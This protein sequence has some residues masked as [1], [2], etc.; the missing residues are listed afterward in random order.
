MNKKVPSAIS[1]K[2]FRCRAVKALFVVWVLLSVFFGIRVTTT[3]FF[4]ATNRMFQCIACG[5][6]LHLYSWTRASNRLNENGRHYNDHFIGRIQ[7]NWLCCWIYVRCMAC[8]ALHIV[9]T[10]F[11]CAVTRTNGRDISIYV[12]IECIYTATNV[13]KWAYHWRAWWKFIWLLHNYKLWARINWRIII[14]WREERKRCLFGWVLR[15]MS[16]TVDS[17]HRNEKKLLTGDFL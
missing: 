17:F 5:I 4:A 14:E 2:L 16:V 7:S 9:G 11:L 15:S 10:S 13:C 1:Q 3:Q 6:K 8:I 12:D